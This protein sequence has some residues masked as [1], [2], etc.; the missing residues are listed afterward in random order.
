[1]LIPYALVLGKPSKIKFYFCLPEATEQKQIM[2]VWF[3]L[4]LVVIIRLDHFQFGNVKTKLIFNFCWSKKFFFV[5]VTQ[6][7]MTKTEDLNLSQICNDHFYYQNNSQ[8]LSERKKFHSTRCTYVRPP[9]SEV[10]ETLMHRLNSS[11]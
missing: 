5:R 2:S 7:K 4:Y 11:A 3:R 6:S 8:F 1:M 10:R 9:S